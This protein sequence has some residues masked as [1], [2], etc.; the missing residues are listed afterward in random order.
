MNGD[1]ASD[2]LQPPVMPI[3]YSVNNIVRNIGIF[4]NTIEGATNFGVFVQ[5]AC[6]GNANN[7][8]NDLSILGNTITGD[9][10]N[11]QCLFY[12]VALWPPDCFRILHVPN[13]EAVRHGPCTQ[14]VLSPPPDVP[15][16]YR[17]D[18]TTGDCSARRIRA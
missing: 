7:T 6:C 5:V 2:D 4:A 12:S 3:Q 17:F 13:R 1:G 14:R 16:F 8:I 9:F 18:R 11:P 15:G 10:G